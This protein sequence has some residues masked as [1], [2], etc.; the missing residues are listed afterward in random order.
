DGQMTLAAEDGWTLRNDLS[1]NLGNLG[2]QLYTGLDVGR[3]GGPSAEY[4]ASRTLVG[5]VAGL[6][7][8]IA[9]PG[10][11]NAV[12]A[13]YDLSAGWPLKKPDNLKTQSTVFAATLMFEF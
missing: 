3:V 12:N 7:G 9:I 8:R 13:S 4:L 6:R 10:V 2:Q 5:A 1:L 11:A